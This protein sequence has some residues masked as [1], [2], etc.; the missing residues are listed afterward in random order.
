MK[1]PFFYYL[2]TK[3]QKSKVTTNGL[4]SINEPALWS[5]RYNDFFTYRIIAT[6]KSAY[7]L[8][9]L[10]LFVRGAVVGSSTNKF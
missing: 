9:D 6:F 3:V 2:C 5:I 4:E 10:V 7:R 1:L 8:S